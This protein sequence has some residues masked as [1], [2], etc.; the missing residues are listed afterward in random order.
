MNMNLKNDIVLVLALGA[1]FTASVADARPMREWDWHMPGSVYKMLEFTDRA[2]VDR[3]VKLF[4]Q[5]IDAEDRGT[6]V[7]DLIP[8][9]RAAAG[10]WKKVEMQGETEEFN[11]PL[12]A[13]AVFMQGY[14]RQQAH[15]R[16]EAAKLY[17]NVL[18]L[19]PE[20][21]FIAVPAK[22]MLYQID[23]SVGDTKK[24]LT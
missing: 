14:A 11:A 3:A 13:Y 16:N 24:A 7:T 20:Q 23:R 9:Y 2:A 4:Q 1:A 6:K 5:A 10:E 8:R 17:N 15:D 19:Y 12:L 21:K 18:D 22:F